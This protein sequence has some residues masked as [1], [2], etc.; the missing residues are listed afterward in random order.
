MLALR[1][2]LYILLS[3]QMQS[4]AVGRLATVFAAGYCGQ[5]FAVGSSSSGGGGDHHHHLKQAS[6]QVDAN[7]SKINKGPQR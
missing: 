1:V 6:E 7:Q 5:W 3:P 2:C 4:L